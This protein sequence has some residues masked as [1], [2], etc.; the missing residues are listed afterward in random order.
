MNGVRLSRLSDRPAA[1]GNRDDDSAAEL[2][3]DVPAEAA[4]QNGDN[5]LT[6]WIDQRSPQARDAL[7][8][9][10]AW[11]QVTCQ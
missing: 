9:K 6:V 8:L 1:T 5:T 3:W 10:E 11:L 7:T 4:A 2:H